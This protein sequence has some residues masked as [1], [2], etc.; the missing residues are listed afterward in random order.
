MTDLLVINPG[1]AET[2]YQGLADELIAVEPPLWCRLIAG[3]VRDWGWSV[4]ILDA[5]AE[6]LGPEDVAVMAA[7]NRPRLICVA[8]YGHQPNAST[9][10]MPETIAVCRAL[11]K[12]SPT[13]PVIIVGGHVAALPDQ[14][15]VDTGA[16]YACSGEGPVTVER[17]LGMLKGGIFRDYV[18]GLVWKGGRNGPAPLIE[19]M[20]ALHGNAWDLLPM[21]KYRA[22]NWQCFG[23]LGTRQPY[24]SIY[25]SLGCP[26]KCSFCC[27]NAPFG[28]PGYRMRDPAD[29]VAEVAMLHDE[30][31]V[32]TF[33]I[34]DEMFVLNP[35][36][37]GAIC[38]G[39]AALPYAADLNI[40]AY[41]RIDTVKAGKLDLLRRAGIRWLALG[42]ESGSAHVRDGAEKS[43]GDD[44]IRTTV[45]AIQDAGINVIGN[46]IFGLPD[47]TWESM[48]A[49]LDLAL[50]LRCEFANFYSAMAYPGSALYAQAKSED[51][52]A[53]WA[54][55]SQH[56]FDTR[57]LPTATLSSLDVLGFRDRAFIEYFSDPAYLDMVGAKFGPETRA[58]VE[59]MAARRLQ[60]AA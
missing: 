40:W 51:L 31:G 11:K 12:R 26:F 15:L 35:K 28:G 4:R 48:R 19:N 54:G 5:A 56:G 55:Y 27:I 59:R 42:I 44:D 24:A 46:F 32:S 16:D 13:T 39:L 36:H 43:F 30:Y 45:K 33:K 60:R 38:E 25:T 22:H 14:S 1:G 3:Y 29:V 50:S 37:Y 20:Q 9:H 2:I 47:D 6:R 49:T 17:L 34:V 58:H 21:A 8:A 41:A 23:D 10:T 52:P 57:P 18:L 7:N 53:S